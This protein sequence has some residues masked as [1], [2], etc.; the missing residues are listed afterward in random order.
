MAG[1]RVLGIEVVDLMDLL[2]LHVNV[3]GEK[4][5]LM[6]YEDG[7]RHYLGF[8]MPSFL[9]EPKLA[10]IY[11]VM[12][13][14]P[15]PVYFFNIDGREVFGEGFSSEASAINIP[16]SFV[17]S[18][19]HSYIEEVFGDSLV[20]FV[21]VS[22]VRSLVVVAHSIYFEMAEIPYVWYD[23]GRDIYVLNV[24]ISDHDHIGNMFFYVPGG[25]YSGPYIYLGEDLRDIGVDLAPNRL[26]RKYVQVIRVKDIP[27]L[28][29]LES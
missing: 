12:G 8:Y 22:D 14:K 21:K 3:K 7:G 2:R 23:V 20:S 27:Y 19:P 18:V 16:V 29:A 26:E 13:R 6:A 4:P 11:H 24:F 25:G 10:Y 28:A 15:A 5:G 1:L 17:S 9:R